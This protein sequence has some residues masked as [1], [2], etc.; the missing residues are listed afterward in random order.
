MIHRKLIS[1]PIETFKQVA[2]NRGTGPRGTDGRFIKSPSK[3]K[4]A[5]VIDSKDDLETPL[6]DLISPKTPEFPNTTVTKRGSIDRGRPKLIRDRTSTSSPQTSPDN[7]T[8]Q[9]SNMGPLNIITTNMTDTEVD[10]A[11]EDAKS[12]EQEFFIRDENGEVFSDNKPHPSTVEDNLENFDLDLASNLS[13]STEIE[14]EEKEPIRRSKSL[15]KTIP[16]VRYNNSVCFCYDYRSHRRKA[17]FGPHTES[18]GSWTG[19]GKQQPLNQSND[20]IQTS[21]TANHHNTHYSRERSTAHQ[22]LDQWRNN[23]HSEKKNAP[24]VRPSANSRGGN[25]EDRQTHLNYLVCLYYL[26]LLI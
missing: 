18:N 13:S 5:M 17:E 1:K 14:T 9:G 3:Q 16:I 12:A 22:T 15:T 26:Y 21:R 11:I 19:G 7:T 25:V 10:R 4:R 2:N 23:R 24:I 8:T 20:K 6:M